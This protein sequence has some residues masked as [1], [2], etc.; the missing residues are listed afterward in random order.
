MTFTCPH[1]DPREEWCLL[2]AN[3]C[4]PGRPGCVLR[5]KATFLVPVEERIRL[6]REAREKREGLNLAE[7]TVDRPGGRA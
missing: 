4:V 5:H 6:A 2:L 7:R 3:D 1:L